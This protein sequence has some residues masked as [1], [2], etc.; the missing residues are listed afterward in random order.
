MAVA[1]ASAELLHSAMYALADNMVFLC[2][3]DGI[4]V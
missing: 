2:W 1:A 3:E 4:A